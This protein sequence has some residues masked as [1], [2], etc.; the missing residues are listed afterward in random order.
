[1]FYLGDTRSANDIL[2]EQNQNMAVQA[3]TDNL[4]K[5]CRLAESMKESLIK[6]E[7]DA[8]GEI[9][10]ES[11]RL[12][13]ELASGVSNAEIDGLYERA[14][15]AGAAGGKLLGAGGGG[16]MLFY[17]VPEKQA[18]LCAALNLKPMPFA[19]DYDGTSIIYIGDKY[20]DKKT[21]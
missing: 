21:G 16:F 19:F 10:N 18:S 7:L 17:C 3:K 11:W 20:W 14:L 5:M 13:R 4:V 15:N 12:K 9:L 2:R 1:M 6:N 8:F